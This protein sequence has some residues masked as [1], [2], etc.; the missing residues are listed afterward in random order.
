VDNLISTVDYN[1]RQIDGDVDDVLSLGDL[2]A[3][4]IA[5]GWYVMETEG[6][7]MAALL[8]TLNDAKGRSGK[9]R[10][11]MI[12]MRTEMGQGVDFM[13]NSHEWHGIAPN[14]QQL[15]SALAQLEETMG[16]Y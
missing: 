4:W 14:D 13:M 8:A 2:K 1:G 12:L 9:G 10:P 3:K 5:F 15:A 11:I 16:D 7:D 6:N